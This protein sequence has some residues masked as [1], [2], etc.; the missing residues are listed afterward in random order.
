MERKEHVFR[1]F[2]PNRWEMIKVAINGKTKN[3]ARGKLRKRYPKL[4]LIKG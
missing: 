1:W 4:E 2:D 3:K